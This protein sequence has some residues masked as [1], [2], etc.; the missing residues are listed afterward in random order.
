MGRLL[1]QVDAGF[2]ALGVEQ[3]EL[4]PLG[5]FRKDGEVRTPA[6]VGRAQRKGLSEPDVYACPSSPAA[7][8]GIDKV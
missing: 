4:D 1:G 6:V 5:D 2:V 8:A 3:T 7:S